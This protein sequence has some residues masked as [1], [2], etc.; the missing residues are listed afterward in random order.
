MVFHCNYIIHMN[1][2]LMRV[3]NVGMRRS[4]EPNKPSVH[5]WLHFIVSQATYID[6]TTDVL[7][8]S[9]KIRPR[10]LELD[11][12]VQPGQSQILATDWDW[13]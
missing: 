8:A 12:R 9:P 10:G 4:F 7:K 13:Y 2:Q 11:V 1:I 6:I 5:F 3:P